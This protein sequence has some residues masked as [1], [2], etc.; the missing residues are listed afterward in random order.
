MTHSEWT[1]GVHHDGSARYVSEPLPKLGQLVRL[2]LRAP[3][4]A[5]IIRAFIRTAPDGE[6]HLAPMQRTADDGVLQWWEGDLHVSM[7]KN[8]YRFKLI[9]ESGEAY[10][11]N[12]AGIS[13]VDRPDWFDFRIVADFQAPTW[14]Y[15]SVFYEIFPDR[16]YNGD[17]E[18]TPKPGEWTYRNFPVSNQAWGELPKPYKDSGNVNFY[19]GDLPG[20]AQKLDYLEELGVN[21]IYLTPI[22][23]STS[24]HR[25]DVS[26]FYHIDPHLGGD[27]GLA[28]LRTALDA[29]KFR[30][31]LDITLNHCGFQNHWFTDAQKDLNSPTAE[32][33]TFYQNDPNQ[34]ASWLGVRSLPKL[35]YR[36][37]KLRAAMWGDEDSVMRRWLRAP[38]R[39]DGWRLDVANMQG[40]Q[41][42]YQLGH[43]IG[44]ALRK[45]VKAENPDAYIFG[46]HFYDGTPHLQGDELDA[47]M[48]YAGFT[49]ALWQ[50]LSGRENGLE[51]RPDSVDTQLLPAEDMAAQWT[52]YRAAIPYAIQLQQFLLL[53][54]HD[55]AR[56]SMKMGGD[57]A[58]IKL[59][60]FMQM[61]YP[62][63]PCV[64]YGDEIGLEGGVDPDNRRTMPWDRAEWDQEMLAHYKK[65]IHLRRTQT[66]LQTGG[67]QQLYAQDGLVSFLR[68][69]T[70][71]RLLVVGYRGAE[72]RAMHWLPIWQAGFREGAKLVDLLSGKEYTVS[73]GAITLRQV[74]HGAC[75]LLQEA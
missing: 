41:G 42:P 19:G 71:Q 9:T 4:G 74:E 22:F 32:F 7:P 69:A 60:A 30:L 23:V 48:N 43:K 59:A 55:T 15:S 18:L 63:V 58:L 27:D 73:E 40:K 75:Y 21:A 51:W 50:W 67:F 24:N 52:S 14:V 12:A 13:R 34:Y 28:A 61:T 46:E 54:S 36:S 3:S 16:F 11:L 64:Y 38:Y 47:S 49:F 29:K 62:G 5:P 57:K 39:I 6:N 17:P 68:E 56:V 66:A 31:I 72:T 26:D 44:R 2:K 70:D 10:H 25:Y 37:E 35:N 20:I 45:A 53:D 1:A 8:H 65:I 33:F